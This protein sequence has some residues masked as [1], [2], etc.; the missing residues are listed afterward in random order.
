MRL[1]GINPIEQHVEKIVFVVALAGLVGVLLW[2]LASPPATMKVGVR[3]QR[4]VE[5]PDA[6]NELN[7]DAGMLKGEME[8]PAP[9]DLPQ[10]E[11]GTLIANFQQGKAEGVAPST[12]LAGG[13]FGRR[14]PALT[15]VGPDG[16]G[17]GLDANAYVVP[18]VPAPVQIAGAM[19]Q[20]T[21]H[22]AE[23]AKVPELGDL[24]QPEQPFDIPMVS[25]QGVFD[26]E[27]LK[28]RFLPTDGQARQIPTAW[29]EGRTEIFEVILERQQFVSGRWGAV[30]RIARVPGRLALLADIED[31]VTQEEMDDLITRAR[32]GREAL[33]R[34]RAPQFIYGP[35][36]IEPVDVVPVEYDPDREDT[37]DRKSRQLERALRQLER[38]NERIAD[39]GLLPQLERQRDQVREQ[40][41]TIGAELRALGVDVEGLEDEE[42]GVPDP[43]EPGPADG[44]EEEEEPKL[45]E[46]SAVRIWRHDLTVERGATY[47]Y[48]LRV[49]INSPFFIARASLGEDQKSLADEPMLMGEASEWSDPITVDPR[50]L[51]FVT[52]ASAGAQIGNARI[53]A[54][55]RAEVE[56]FTFYKGEYRSTKVTLEPGDRVAAIVT[57]PD[58]PLPSIEEFEE[59]A[60]NPGGR[61]PPP[62]RDPGLDPNDPN[63]PLP[64]QPTVDLPV[65][66]EYII[67][68][69]EST[70]GGTRQDEAQVYI[71]GPEGLVALHLPSVDAAMQLYKRAA[72]SALR[73]S[74][75][76][77][78]RR[79]DIS[80]LGPDGDFGPGPGPGPGDDRDPFPPPDGRPGERGPGG[81]PGF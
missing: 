77:E 71:V 45:L 13:G 9:Q 35:E 50:D 58:L 78:P 11:E 75:Q 10:W 69:V 47:R 53:G 67:A 4:D 17:P 49:V 44:A 25:I 20:G 28:R 46:D 41:T 73:G 70:T 57:A 76:V 3:G 30:E 68:E 12:Q 42:P 1:K 6:Y 80:D 34:P 81:R 32:D 48:R 24:L 2:Q 65:S 79:I 18:V 14:S 31:G 60:D 39:A 5:L 33:R 64:E 8:Q 29:F 26:G 21:V 59:D 72:V 74:E 38:I 51:F 27:E 15:G 56:V 66:L 54:S 23:V 52:G 16:I 7:R 43:V 40:I 63:A 61:R 37:I 19:F 55:A 22:P 36:W 62:P